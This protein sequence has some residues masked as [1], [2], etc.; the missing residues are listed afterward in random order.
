LTLSADYAGNAGNLSSSDTE[1]HQVERAT[2]TLVITQDTPDPSQAG[3]AI[4][5]TV[6]LS[7]NA[8]SNLSLAGANVVVSASG[9]SETCTIVLPA[10]SC[11]LNLSGI[12]VRT[13]SANFAGNPSIQE[14]S[15]TEPHTV[16]DSADFVFRNGF[17]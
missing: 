9:G 7:A 13:L 5:V 12:G 10:T 11:V 2:S 17:E 6:A 16:E 15:D 1:A 3:E 14:S 4:T 8:P